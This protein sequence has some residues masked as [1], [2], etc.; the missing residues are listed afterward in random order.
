MDAAAGEEDA[1]ASSPTMDSNGKSSLHTPPPPTQINKL[2]FAG[3]PLIR[4][5]RRQS[6]SR[7]NVSSNRELVKLG[8]LKDAPQNEREELFV[9]KIKQCQ[10]LFDF[11]SDPLSDLKWKEVSRLSSRSTS[12]PPCVSPSTPSSFWKQ[13]SFIVC[14]FFVLYM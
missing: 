12:S 10:V 6:S 7:F 13:F 5:D 4:K 11:V 3:G 2:K 1:S 14:S 8:A 9:E